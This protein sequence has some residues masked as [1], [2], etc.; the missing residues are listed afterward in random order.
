MMVPSN[1]ALSKM[2]A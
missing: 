1:D 2:R